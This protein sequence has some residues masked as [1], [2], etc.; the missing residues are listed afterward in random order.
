MSKV[1]RRN[2]LMGSAAAVGLAACQ[3]TVSGPD[4]FDGAASAPSRTRIH[5]A[6]LDEVVF[7]NEGRT[8]MPT[9]PVGAWPT[10]SMESA[11]PFTSLYYDNCQYNL[12]AFTHEGKKGL[13]IMEDEDRGCCD[14]TLTESEKEGLRQISY[15]I[16]EAFFGRQPEQVWEI[17]ELAR[18]QPEN[19]NDRDDRPSNVSS[20]GGVLGGG[21]VTGP[22]TTLN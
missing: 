15:Q 8:S 12:I 3:T 5:P 22:T 21:T 17:K 14:T 20:G 6:T 7:G 2:F 18:C 16:C 19:D 13:K 1:S 9:S 4:G 11:E 10:T